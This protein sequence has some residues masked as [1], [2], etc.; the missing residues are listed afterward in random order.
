MSECE[1]KPQATNSE[2]DLKAEFE[3]QY[4][5]GIL[6]KPLDFTPEVFKERFASITPA[7]RREIRE[8]VELE[9]GLIE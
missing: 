2:A 6:G 7:V 3:A 8:K 1:E 5:K 4:R 9:Y